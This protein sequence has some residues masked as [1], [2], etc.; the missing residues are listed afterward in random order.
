MG[1]KV[2][3][4]LGAGFGGITAALE[5]RRGL[6]A[7]HH[8]ILLDRQASFMMGLRKLWI[9]AGVGTR[10]EGTRSLDRLKA[11]GIDFRQTAVEEIP[12]VG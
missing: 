1:G 8:I 12:P 11:K 10:T 6:G 2:I 3:V 7:E 9:L 4:I 5:L